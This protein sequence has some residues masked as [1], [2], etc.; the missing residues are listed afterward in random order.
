M[1]GC[2]HIY[3]QLYKQ[4]DTFKRDLQSKGTIDD[5]QIN[6]HLY[7]KHNNPHGKRSD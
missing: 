7:Q 5:E 1:W 2:L 3:R 4:Y 6:F